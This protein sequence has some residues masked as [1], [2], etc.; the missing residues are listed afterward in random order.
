MI[1]VYEKILRKIFWYGILILFPVSSSQGS[2][3][4]QA[5]QSLFEKG[6]TS[7]DTLLLKKA[8]DQAVDGN[9]RP[10]FLFKATCLW[11]IQIVKFVLADKKG[12]V[13]QGKRALVFLDSAENNGADSFAVASIRAFT[14]QLL[15]GTSLA[16]GARYGPLT[17]TH[18]STLRKMR[19]AAYETRLVDAFN[20]LEAPAFVGGDPA[21]ALG[22]GSASSL[23]F[24]QDSGK[25]FY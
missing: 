14:T 21:T 3:V 9:G 23:H 24:L 1:T 7:Y 19:P 18:L 5:A 16:N 6:I 10:D 17:G 2:S 25:V 8:F 4:S 20:K 15:A 12:A 11:R 22:P 13:L